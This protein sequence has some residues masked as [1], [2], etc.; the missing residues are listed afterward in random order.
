MDRCRTDSSH[1]GTVL[2]GNWKG[3]WGELR[4][5]DTW[6]LVMHFSSSMW[7]YSSIYAVGWV[8]LQIET[9]RAAMRAQVYIHSKPYLNSE[10][11]IG[12]KASVQLSL[13]I[14]WCWWD[15]W[16]RENCFIKSFMNSYR[17]KPEASPLSEW[18]K[19]RLWWKWCQALVN[20]SRDPSLPPFTWQENSQAATSFQHTQLLLL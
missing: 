4:R 13:C 14:H 18:A 20:G 2:Q 10:S 7:I 9:L 17:G 12:C 11:S 6:A 8:F 15:R 3:F 16:P 19:T 1:F 5:L